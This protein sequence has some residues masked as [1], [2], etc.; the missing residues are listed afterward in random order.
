M[1]VKELKQSCEE[2]LLKELDEQCKGL[3]ARKNPSVLRNNNFEDMVNFD[4]LSL[5]DE[6]QNRC[7]FLLKV[8]HTITAKKK[9]QA[10]LAP[11]IG[12]AFAIL[13]MQR[14]HELSLVQRINTLIMTEGNAKKQVTR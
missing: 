12:M 13:M 6:L 2:I 9:T 5:L 3:C 11:C 10:E 8:F 7:P 14:N 1:S 4:W